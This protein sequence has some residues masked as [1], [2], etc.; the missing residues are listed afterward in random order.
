MEKLLSIVVPVYNKELFIDRCM[1]SLINLNIEKEKIE[2]IFVDDMSTDNSVSEI[3][4]YLD[5]Y[6]FIKLIKLKENTGSPAIPRNIGMENATGKYLVLLD[7]DDWLDEEGIPELLNQCITHD[8]DFGFGHAIKHTE[9]IITKL[10]RFTS[11]TDA[12][13]LIPYEIHNI[14]R[15]VG[16]PGKMFKRSIILDNDIKFMNLKFGED[17]LFF[18]EAIC[19]S[20]TASMY[21]KP[22]YHVNRFA[23]NESLVGQTS[24]IE[25]SKINLVVLEEIIKMDLPSSGKFQAINRIVEVDFLARLFNRVRFLKAKDKQEYYDV[26]YELVKLLNRYNLSIEEYITSKK[27]KVIYTLIM[28]K[29]HDDLGEYINLLTQGEKAPKYIEEKTLYFYLP[30]NLQEFHPITEEMFVVFNG[31]RKKDGILYDT[32]KIYSKKIDDINNVILSKLNDE[33]VEIE[34]PYFIEKNLIFIKKDDL[35]FKNNDFNI[36]VIYDNFK[37]KIV[38][39]TYPSSSEN[40]KMLRQSYK[41]EFARN[42]RTTNLDTPTPSFL[43]FIKDTVKNIV[44]LQEL[45]SYKDNEFTNLQPQKV[46]RGTLLKVKDSLINKNGNPTIILENGDKINP[47]FKNIMPVDLSKKDQ[48]ILEVPKQIR[49]K[50]KCFLYRDI[51]FKKEKLE[52]VYPGTII[53]IKEIRYTKKLTPRLVTADNKYLTANKDF[54]VEV[55]K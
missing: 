29:R 40:Y 27:L 26:F 19:K 11:Y 52:E 38:N 10:G 25:K 36:R 55:K 21:S 24:I 54:V 18:I 51:E 45:N 42:D 1:E 41:S 3:E 35:Y 53:D 12:N 33:S 22:V 9:N 49:V 4:K 2:A 8:S 16:P 14:F 20:K 32:I 48:Y 46:K 34:I 43:K 50:K 7:A 39:A 13:D 15:A 17:K 23:F 6:P 30:N 47:S 31:G 44:A 37:T 5:E 28:Q